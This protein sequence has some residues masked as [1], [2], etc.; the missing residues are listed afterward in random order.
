MDDEIHARVQATSIH[1]DL[2]KK[3]LVL[4]A[5]ISASP[6]PQGRT[7]STTLGIGQIPLKAI[8]IY[9]KFVSPKPVYM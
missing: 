6:I 5:S 8:G 2:M 1:L 4:L 9:T 3:S 7:N